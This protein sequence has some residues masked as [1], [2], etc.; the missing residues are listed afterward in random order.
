MLWGLFCLQCFGNILELHVTTLLFWKEIAVLIELQK[1]VLKMVLVL[2][3]QQKSP[4]ISL[5][6]G[7]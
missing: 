7:L 6:E 4:Q 1:V 3:M 5:Q 2:Q